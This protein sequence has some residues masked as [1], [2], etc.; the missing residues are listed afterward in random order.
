MFHKKERRYKIL[1]VGEEDLI[2]SFHHYIT[3]KYLHNVKAFCENLK[4]PE[5]IEI[6]NIN[7]AFDIKGFE[8]ILYHQSFD[9]IPEGKQ[10]PH[11]HYDIQNVEVNEEKLENR[12]IHILHPNYDDMNKIDDDDDKEVLNPYLSDEN[13]DNENKEDEEVIDEKFFEELEEENEKDHKEVL[14]EYNDDDKDCEDLEEDRERLELHQNVWNYFEQNN[15]DSF[16]MQYK[17]NWDED[18]ENPYEVKDVEVRDDGGFSLT[19]SEVNKDSNDGN[20]DKKDSLPLFNDD[21]WVDNW[22][23]IGGGKY[24]VKNGPLDPNKEDNEDSDEY[25]DHIQKYDEEDDKVEKWK[26]EDT[27]EVEGWVHNST[28]TFVDEKENDEASNENVKEDYQKHIEELRQEIVNQPRKTA[29]VDLKQYLKPEEVTKEE[30]KEVIDDVVIPQLQKEIL[31]DNDEKI[32][33]A[34]ANSECEDK[35]NEEA[36]YFRGIRTIAADGL[37]FDKN[38]NV[39]QIHL[40]KSSSINNSNENNIEN[41]EEKCEDKENVDAIDKALPDDPK[42]SWEPK[43]KLIKIKD[44]DEP[45]EEVKGSLDDILNHFSEDKE[46]ACNVHNPNVKFFKS[47]SSKD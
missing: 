11:I 3:H 30:L 41:K 32:K 15:D 12:K 46:E 19:L 24:V 45:K 13:N 5:D 22:V 20:E 16:I 44:N 35:D 4:L 29:E 2:E 26:T 6:V 21:N 8:V 14:H 10:I 37:H 27:I 18:K 36:N 1:P 39:K 31:L 17:A 47:G 38:G 25:E 33:E 7:C 23:D 40:D 9:I 28:F 34:L 43:M 42:T